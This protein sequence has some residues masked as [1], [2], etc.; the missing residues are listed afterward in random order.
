[1]ARGCTSSLIP[2]LRWRRLLRDYAR[3]FCCME[4]ALWSLWSKVRPQS[5]HTS[6]FV[7][8]HIL[9]EWQQ[10]NCVTSLLAVLCAQVTLDTPS[11]KVRGRQSIHTPVIP[12]DACHTPPL[13]VTVTRLCI[14]PL[15]YLLSSA[16]LSLV[17]SIILFQVSLSYSLPAFINGSPKLW[18]SIESSIS[19]TTL[20]ALA[21]THSSPLTKVERLQQKFHHLIELSFSLDSKITVSLSFNIYI[22][23]LCRRDAK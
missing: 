6:K 14:I 16:L 10:E 17:L 13:Y 4:T 18:S 5:Y 23:R 3:P 15:L 1:M 11:T 20:F 22:H 19:M 9:F 8:S 12:G 21:H 7:G 2:S